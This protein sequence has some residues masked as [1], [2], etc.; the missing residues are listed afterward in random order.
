MTGEQFA[1]ELDY[2]AAAALAGVMLG[3]GMI[4]E[5]D[6]LRLRPW[7]LEQ[8]QPVISGLRI[9]GDTIGTGE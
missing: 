8:Y 5:A 6:H 1:R 4:D 9:G 3:L 7:A 2:C